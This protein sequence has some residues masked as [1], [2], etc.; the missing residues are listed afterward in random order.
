MSDVDVATRRWRL[1]GYTSRK[2]DEKPSHDS[3]VTGDQ[4][5][6]DAMTRL[7]RDRGVVRITAE[8]L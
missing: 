2:K 7:E 4:A 6:D 1:R 5:L 3:T 8:P